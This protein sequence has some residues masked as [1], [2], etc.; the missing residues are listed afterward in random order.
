VVDE[1]GELVGVISEADVLEKEAS[2]RYGWGRAVDDAWRRHDAETVGEA[3]SRPALVTTPDMTLR[4]ATRLLLDRR[5]ARLVVVDGGEIAGM[6]TRR[7]VL[8]VLL[9]DDAELHAAVIAEL[10]AANQPEAHATVEWGRV[11]LSG[12]VTRRSQVSGLVRRI[13]E[14]DGV[15]SVASDLGWTED[16]VSVY[17]AS[18]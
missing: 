11:R 14:V 12:Q 3:C 2:R 6:I 18:E 16:D 15:M 13:E 1:A 5:V 4:D 17:P 8:A 10:A 7:D 9:R